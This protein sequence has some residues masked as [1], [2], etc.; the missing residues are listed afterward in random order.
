MGKLELS[1]Q[2]GR[3]IR[4]EQLA[5]VSDTTAER[6]ALAL[7]DGE[8]VVAFEI[9]RSKG[10]NEVTLARDVREVIQTLG[11][12]RPDI[13]IS[14]QIDNVQ[15]TE[16]NFEGSMHLLYEGAILAVIVVW[17]F[18]RDW[19]ATIVSA[20]ALPLSIRLASRSTW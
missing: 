4:L 14:E 17:Y 15:K 9:M 5:V 16:E 7:V 19:R 6:R 1:L 18:L 11:V 20:A 13:K 8:A 3:R 2:D 12:A 10:A